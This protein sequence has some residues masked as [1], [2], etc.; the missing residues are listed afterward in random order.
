MTD[1]ELLALLDKLRAVMISVATGGARIG[2]V[3][4]EFQ[5]D[6]RTVA[7]ELRNREIENPLPYS[8]LWQW[9]GKWSADIA[10]YGPRRAYVAD[11][12]APLIS[13]VRASRVAETP[14]TGWARVDRTIVDARERLSRAKTEEQFQAIGLLCREALISVAQEVFD[15]T[16]HPTEADVRVSTTDY[17]RMIEAYVAV[18]MRGGAAEEV[19]KHARTAL[20]LALRLQ[21]QRTAGFRD[22][23]ICIEATSAVVGIIAIVSGRRDP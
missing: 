3:N 2:E 8:D 18:E 7:D 10:G 1:P 17:K 19:R 9:Y 22:A 16:K 6:Y 4:N 20:D 5:E 14:P 13:R 11:L 15:P 21:H 23:A 12:F